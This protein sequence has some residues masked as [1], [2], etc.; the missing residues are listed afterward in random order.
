ME[1]CLAVNNHRNGNN[2]NE[3]YLESMVKL[4]AGHE[5]RTPLNGIVGFAELLCDNRMNVTTEEQ[6]E[7]LKH[8]LVSTKRLNNLSDRLRIWFTLRQRNIISSKTCFIER[9]W[10]ETILLNQASKEL[11]HSDL[12]RFSPHG[13]CWV[14]NG[15]LNL[16]KHILDELVSNAFKFSNKESIVSI[17]IEETKSTVEF[18][19]T[20][21]TNY[22]TA[23]M[24]E[25]YIA[26]KQ[27]E[28]AKME[29]QGL[30]IGIEIAKLSLE[31]CGGY[32]TFSN[33]FIENGNLLTAKAIFRK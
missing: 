7:Y 10:V 4:L 24:M 3:Y 16:I 13:N 19:I 30:G 32:L 31:K 18:T 28:R 17:S 23:E 6:T 5:F 21:K 15:E 25:E 14:V 9:D 29:Q 2:I 8:I 1:N 22:A 26:F 27:F 12:F 33:R 11:A 20:N